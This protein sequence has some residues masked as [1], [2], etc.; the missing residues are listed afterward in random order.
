MPRLI[1]HADLWALAANVAI[2]AM[3]GPDI[4]TRFGRLDSKSAS[5]GLMDPQGRLPAPEKDA[6]HLREVFGAKGFDENDVVALSGA[7]T[8]GQCHLDRS[9]FQGQWTDVG[10]SKAFGSFWILLGLR[11]S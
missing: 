2:K 9:G 8:V 4:P 10:A 11:I 3:G 1:S 6:Q 7:H 5:E